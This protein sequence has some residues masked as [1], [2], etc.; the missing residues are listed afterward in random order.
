MCKHD[1]EVW[2]RVPSEPAL[3]GLTSLFGLL[4]F[5]TIGSI[6]AINVRDSS[7]AWLDVTGILSTIATGI[8]FLVMMV[9]GD[10]HE[11]FEKINKNR[12]KSSREYKFNGAFGI[13]DKTCLKCNKKVW[14]VTKRDAKA[15]ARKKLQDIKDADSKEKQRIRR[16]KVLTAEDEYIEYGSLYR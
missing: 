6:I 11:R 4:L 1:W 2:R 7:P 5:T 16:L 8:M 3:I 10:W 13:V 15:D 9:E 12:L 14:N